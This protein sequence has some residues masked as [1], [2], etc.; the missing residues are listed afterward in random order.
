MYSIFS[1]CRANLD[2][3]DF[4]FEINRKEIKHIY[5]RVYPGKKKIV[6]SAPSDLDARELN[7][8]IL[9]KKD[10]LLKKIK[11]PVRQIKSEK[12]QYLTDDIV[13]F[14]GKPLKLRY[15]LS[16]DRPKVILI[17]DS[18]VHV[19]LKQGSPA[20]SIEKVIPG[21]LR[22]QLKLQIKGLVKKWEP[23]LKVKINEYRIRKMKTRWGSCNITVGRI[24]LNAVL[25]HLP[26][27]FLEYVVVHEMVHLLERHHNRR[28]KQ[29]MDQFVPQW[30]TLKK[31]MDRFSL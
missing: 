2:V 4:S 18:H 25:I 5:F 1:H 13:W 12:I 10:W 9:S 15:F 26:P 14:K 31:E 3:E 24:W 20:G 19:F 21:W 22:K 6:V 11:E 30:R 28:F 23:I 16:N 8:A 29:Y 17:N 7:R 27:A